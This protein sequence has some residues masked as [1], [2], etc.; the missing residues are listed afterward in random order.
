[1]LDPSQ[2]RL[3]LSITNIDTGYMGQGLATR[4]LA[5]GHEASLPDRLE[6]YRP[7]YPRVSTIDT[8]RGSK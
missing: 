4:L 3:E 6:A 8:V 5:G 2:R 7:E 1:M